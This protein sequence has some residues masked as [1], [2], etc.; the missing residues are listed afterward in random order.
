MY[1]TLDRI[2]EIMKQKG[3]KDNEIE[4]LLG[5]PRGTFSNWKRGK[6]RSYYEHI[7]IIADRIGVSID[8]LIRGGD[9]KPDLLSKQ[10]AGLL[11]GFRKLSDELLQSH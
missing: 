4:M 9:K 6:S 1:E 3:I 2:V 5:V 7:D 11:E 8:Y 10:E